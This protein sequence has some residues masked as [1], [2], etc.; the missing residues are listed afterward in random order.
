MKRIFAFICGIAILCG[1]M[2]PMSISGEELLKV[3]KTTYTQGEDILV[4][5]IGDGDDWVGI[6]QKSD[7]IPDV[8]SILWYYVD[9]EGNSSGDTK[10]IFDS[11]YINRQELADLPAGEYK[12]CLFADGGYD[13][14]AQKD[15]TIKANAASTPTTSVTEKTL[16]TNK[17]M[18]TEGEPILTTAT[19]EGLDWVGL[20]LRDDTLETD[21]SIRW[22]YVAKDGNTSGTEKNLRVAEGTNASRAAYADVPAGEYTIY[23]CANDK[24]DILAQVDIT[25]KAVANTQTAP[26]APT[27]VTYERANSFT[28]AADGKLIITAGEDTLPDSYV[29]YWANA[30]GPLANYTAFAPI[31]CTGKVTEYEMVA[32]TLIPKE[33][34]RILVYAVRKEKLSAKATAVQL[35]EGCNTYDFGTP[36][37]EMQVMSDIHLN[38]SQK[39]I[40][41]VH[42]AAALEDIKTISPNSIGI[43][44]NGDIADHG[45]VSEYRSL[46]KIIDAA[47]EGLPKVYCSIGNHDLADGPYDEKLKNFLEYTEPGTDSVYYDLWLN[48]VHFIFL[49]SEAPGLNAQLSNKQLE[50]FREK[51]AENRDENRPI[52]VFLHQGLIDTVA[53][54]FAYQE[55]HGINQAKKFA[56]ILKDYPEVILFSGHSHWEM[57]SLHSMKARD[58][59]LPTIFNTAA[60]AYL[61]NDGSMSTNVGIEGSQ[62]YYIQAYADKI[63]VLGRDY[64]NGKWI[65]SAQYLVQYTQSGNQNSGENDQ[66]P[67]NTEG[68][69]GTPGNTDSVTPD[70]TEPSEN[71]FSTGAVVGGAVGVLA[72]AAAVVGLVVMKKKKAAK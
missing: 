49:G 60:V 9:K 65:A 3:N 42:F 12:V 1:A 32:N 38:A 64:V 23:L 2:F 59:A 55:W 41:N 11:E 70:Y 50:W 24:W 57:D 68:P 17:T 36:L 71:A 44:I 69:D 62:G 34:D 21:Q 15:I 26:Q 45:Y 66:T 51:L 56:E 6:Y 61:W 67:G 53:G 25:V 18:Y 8:T 48:D 47:G 29:A 4:T 35:P 52:Y 37:Y 40:H 5:A 16:K 31:T 43:F 30:E 46:Q 13:I 72:V 28:G 10:N 39:H 63:L 58:E 27:S 19:G 20:Y 14:L 33:A 54:T 7:T 22:Y